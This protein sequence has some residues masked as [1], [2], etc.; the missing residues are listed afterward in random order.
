VEGRMSPP[1]RE[2]VLQYSRAIQNEHYRRLID[3]VG[4]ASAPVAVDGG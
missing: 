3:R 1:T 2:S 4:L